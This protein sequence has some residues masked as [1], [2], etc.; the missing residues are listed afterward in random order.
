MGNPNAKPRI[1]ISVA[2]PALPII[3]GGCI[4]L[5]WRS[6]SLVM[7]RWFNAAGL[8]PGIEPARS[9]A[10]CMRSHLPDW[11]VYSVP[12]AAWVSC[13]VLLFAAIWA[14]SFRMRL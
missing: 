9:L 4:Y 5:L 2:A 1:L 10:V 6:T 11:F 14:G 8:M 3:F 7:F 13:G 12:D